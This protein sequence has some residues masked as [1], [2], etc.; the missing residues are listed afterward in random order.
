MS[1]KN[2]HIWNKSINI[3]KNVKFRTCA[4]TG[5]SREA[6]IGI[7]KEHMQGYKNCSVFSNG[8]YLLCTAVI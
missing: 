3:E 4:S 2:A 5:H 8:L 6:G 7:K 1:Y